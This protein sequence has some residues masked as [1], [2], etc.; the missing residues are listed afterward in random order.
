M[1]GIGSADESSRTWV[2]CPEPVRGD[3]P[4]A[5]CGRRQRLGPVPGRHARR[6]AVVQTRPHAAERVADADG[7]V[8]GGRRAATYVCVVCTVDGCLTA[9]SRSVPVCVPVRARAGREVGP[10]GGAD[11]DNLLPGQLDRLLGSRP[12]RRLHVRSGGS[13]CGEGH[14]CMWPDCWVGRCRLAPGA[15]RFHHLC[16]GQLER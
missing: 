2:P 9:Q 7:H 5:R 12:R 11:A 4:D 15:T 3:L 1:V 13:G 6:M 8:G 10:P 16:G 14:N